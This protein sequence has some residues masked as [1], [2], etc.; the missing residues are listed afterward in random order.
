MAEVDYGCDIKDT[1][2][3]DEKGDFVMVCGLDCASQ[4]IRNDLLTKY[5]ELAELGHTDHGNKSFYWLNFTDINVAIAHVLI[6]TEECLNKQP[7]VDE[8]LELTPEYDNISGVLT[9]KI[10]VRLVGLEELPIP[11]VS[12]FMKDP[13]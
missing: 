11:G 1:W 10:E 8:I 2:E 6:Y 12:I 13:W 4:S 9:V 3:L 7:L 5:G